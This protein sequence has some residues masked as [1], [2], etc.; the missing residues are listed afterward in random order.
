MAKA[1]VQNAVVSGRS[2]FPLD[3]LRYDSCFPA[4]QD[5]V[6]KIITSTERDPKKRSEEDV[7]I[8]IRRVVGNSSHPWTEGRWASF[9]WHLKPST[10]HSW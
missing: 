1:F 4:T 6:G 3:M 5:D 9:G 2:A 10:V 8:A 7:Y